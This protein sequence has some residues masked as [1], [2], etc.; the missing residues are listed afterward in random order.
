MKFVNINKSI[1]SVALLALIAGT[2][3]KKDFLDVNEDPNRA[4]DKNIRAEL[5]FPQAAHGIAGRLA[6]GQ[7]RFLNC[8][9]GYFAQPG[10]F[11]ILQDETSYSID[12]T[13]GDA[14]WQNHYDALYDLYVTKV[15]ALEVQDS[16]LAGC[17]MILSA[18]LFQDLVDTYG[19]IPY[20]QAFQT[21]VYQQPAY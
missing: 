8:W 15:K 11:A 6:S 10:D 9:M 19:N 5:L 3:C 4:T 1:I 12:F 21:L 20:T 16:V 14:L 2:S 7:L 13:F 17:A 18:R